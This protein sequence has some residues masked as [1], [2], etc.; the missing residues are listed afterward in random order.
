[1]LTGEDLSWPS[2]CIG[3]RERDKLLK[4]LSMITVMYSPPDQY[5]Y[6]DHNWKVTLFLAEHQAGAASVI[7]YVLGCGFVESFKQDNLIL[8]DRIT[9]F[10]SSGSHT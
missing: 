8:C 5:R 7:C 3:G 6:G 10:Y 1:M 9:T 2:Y 4:L